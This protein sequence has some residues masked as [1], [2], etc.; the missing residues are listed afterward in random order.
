MEELKFKKRNGAA[1]VWV[2]FVFLILT[3]FMSTILY[4]QRQ[5]ILEAARQN[6]RLQTYYLALAGIDLTYAAI[7]EINDNENRIST[8][9]TDKIGSG[10][11]NPPIEIKTDNVVRGT[12]NVSIDRITEVIDGK[13][14]YWLRITSVGQLKD[15]DVKVKSIMR[16]NEKRITQVIREN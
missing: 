12:A 1:L 14:I 11:D 9:I 7:M 8:I 4:L 13:T 15:K 16:I 5:N 10:I 3:I 2:I 6:E